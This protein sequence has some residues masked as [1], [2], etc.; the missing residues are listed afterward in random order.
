MGAYSDS[1]SHVIS[2]LNFH[3]SPFTDPQPPVIR[4]VQALSAKMILVTWTQPDD[5]SNTVNNFTIFVNS[6]GREIMIQKYRRSDFNKRFPRLYSTNVKGLKPSS[7]YKIYITASKLR[8]GILKTSDPS[9]SMEVRTPKGKINF[10]IDLSGDKNAHCLKGCYS[11]KANF[12]SA[13]LSERAE[14]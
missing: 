6:S 14:F 13:E 3:L 12:Q 1:Y 10:Y 11:L 9:K 7:T 2:L 5:P 4:K 8:N